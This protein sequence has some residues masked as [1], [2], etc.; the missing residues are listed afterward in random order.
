MDNGQKEELIV[1]SQWPLH[2]E[3]FGFSDFTMGLNQLHN[4]D[5]S[6]LPPTDSRFRPDVRHLENGDLEKAVAY[7]QGLEKEQRA[8]AINEATHKP[9]WF[10]EKEDAFTKKN[11]F[12]TNGKYWEAR[13]SRFEKQ[14][15]ENAFIPIF[16]VTIN[17]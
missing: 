4:E 12:F 15:K 10:E 8:R 13:Q 3:Y 7:K 5:E 9:L 17:T 1:V 14:K 11:I 16:K 6:L 2:A